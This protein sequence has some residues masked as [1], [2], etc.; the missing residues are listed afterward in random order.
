[1]LMPAA[2]P[3]A[4]VPTDPLDVALPAGWALQVER[5]ESLALGQARDGVVTLWPDMARD[6]DHLHWVAL[7]EAGHAWDH[8]RLTDADRRRWVEMRG[9]N[10]HA[11]WRLGDLSAQIR[12]WSQIPAEDLADAYAWC[13]MRRDDL[14]QST[15]AGPPTAQQC[16]LL[17]S[18]LSTA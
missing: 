8:A 11:D 1:M 16:E 6:R 13:H 10:P 18:M 3:V 14:W 12:Q 5:G 4:D 15:I 2:Q 9:A 17:R 7:H